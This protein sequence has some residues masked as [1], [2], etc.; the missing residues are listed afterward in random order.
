MPRRIVLVALLVP[1]VTCC[2]KG[3]GDAR[4]GGGARVVDAALA[5]DGGPG[6]DASAADA[7]SLDAARADS[8][9]DAGAADAGPDAGDAGRGPILCTAGCPSGTVCFAGVCVLAT[10]DLD[11]DGHPV[12]SDCQDADPDVHPGASERCNGV[13]DDCDGSIDPP[14]SVD[15]GTFYRDADGDG[16]G[17]ASVRACTMPAGW[18]RVGGDCDDGSRL[19]A[20]GR[21]ETCDSLDNDCDGAVDDGACPGGCSGALRGMAAYFVCTGAR[22]WSAASA[23]CSGRGAHLARVDDNAENNWIRSQA[24]ARG[25]GSVWLGGSDAASEGRWVWSDGAR[26]WTG[27]A[28]GSA[29]GGAYARWSADEPNDDGGEDC[30]EQGA[31]RS[32][33]DDECEET[34]GFVCEL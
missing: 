24:D 25:V 1:A 5:L 3:G 28:G 30:L 20:P 15:A 13:D 11:G 2:A 16:A 29:V 23:V 6:L 10:R 32:W 22:T 9:A 12:A 21:A 26:F 31:D 4:D 33:N 8:G 17:A 19:R 7:S 27:A 14:T 18:S 34:H